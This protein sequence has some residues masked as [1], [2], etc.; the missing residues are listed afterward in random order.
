[1]K[2]LVHDLD[3]PRSTALGF[4]VLRLTNHHDCRRPESRERSQEMDIEL[5]WAGVDAFR[6]SSEVLWGRKS[7]GQ[8][9][10]F[11]GYQEQWRRDLAPI[12][13]D[14]VLDLCGQPIEFVNPDR[15]FVRHLLGSSGDREQEKC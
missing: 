4:R 9:F 1:M 11:I 6:N 14:L 13:P 10:C 12:G 7:V 5:P 8:E 3:Q 2:V 15:V